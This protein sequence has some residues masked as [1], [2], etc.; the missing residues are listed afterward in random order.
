MDATQ[1]QTT[2]KKPGRPKGSG[3]MIQARAGRRFNSA[4]QDELT[5]PGF[6]AALDRFLASRGIQPATSCAGILAVAPI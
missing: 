1:T 5:W 3:R 6:N 2:T 4:F